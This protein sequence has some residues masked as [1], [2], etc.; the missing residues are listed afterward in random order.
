MFT[1]FGWRFRPTLWPTVLALPALIVL[2]GLGT[3]QVERMGWKRDLLA[4]IE[5]RMAE[6]PVALPA[7]VDDAAGWAYRRVSVSGRYLPGHELRLLSRTNQGQ[8][9]HHLLA[10]LERDDLPADNGPAFVLIDRGWVPTAAAPHQVPPPPEGSVT[11]TGILRAPPEQGWMQPD[12]APATNSWFW[13]D[14]P[15][16]AADRGLDAYY[17]A[18]VY[19]EIDAAPD[20]PALPVGGRTRLDV[21]NNHLEYAISWYSFALILVVIYILFHL[22]RAD[23]RDPKDR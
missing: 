10:I 20:G 6:A 11:V 22:R 23:G 7:A 8:A 17:L 2:L 9:G 4:T 21:P 18:P 16:V 1:L 3:W 13:V 19:L 15:A 12:N 5:T 14:L